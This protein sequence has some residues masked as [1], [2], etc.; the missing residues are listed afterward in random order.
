[1]ELFADYL[2]ESGVLKHYCSDDDEDVIFGSLGEWK[3]VEDG[4]EGAVFLGHSLHRTHKGL[5]STRPK[6]PSRSPSPQIPFPQ[7]PPSI[8]T[9]HAPQGH[10]SHMCGVREYPGQANQ[11]RPADVEKKSR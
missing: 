9:A 11:R 4:F 6:Y 2:N 7:L 5:S 8:T 3:D 1:V 10:F